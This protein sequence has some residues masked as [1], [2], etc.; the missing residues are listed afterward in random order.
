MITLAVIALSGLVV[1]A[2]IGRDPPAR[3]DE[4]P[5]V[6]QPPSSKLMR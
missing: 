1:V 6:P 4:E 3:N 2:C 5:L